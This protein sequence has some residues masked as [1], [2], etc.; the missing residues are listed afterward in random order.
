MPSSSA[1]TAR[2]DQKERIM[3]NSRDF[4]KLKRKRYPMPSFIKEALKKTGLEVAYQSRPPYQ[5]N[6]YVG[7]ITRAKQEET[8][9]K[10]LDQML[11]E[12]KSG[13]KYMDMEYH[14]K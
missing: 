10:R 11:S 14:G 13:D 9:Q 5:Q 4:S 8:K 1:K 3:R 12:L 2:R 6:D 7:W